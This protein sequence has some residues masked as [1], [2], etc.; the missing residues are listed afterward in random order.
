MI[1]NKKPHIRIPHETQLNHKHNR[2]SGHF[3]NTRQS[4]PGISYKARIRKRNIRIVSL[5]PRNET[6]PRVTKKCPAAAIVARQ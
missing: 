4:A 6:N 5:A 3:D 2:Q 1:N